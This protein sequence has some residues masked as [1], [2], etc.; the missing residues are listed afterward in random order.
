V[1]N[2]DSRD[3]TADAVVVGV[4][5]DPVAVPAQ[6]DATQLSYLLGVPGRC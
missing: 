2:Q 4:V 3:P 1:T 5:A 6:Y